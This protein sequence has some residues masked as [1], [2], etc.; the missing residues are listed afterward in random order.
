M[1]S[2]EQMRSS[3]TIVLGVLLLVVGLNALRIGDIFKSGEKESPVI[4]KPKI[5][6]REVVKGFSIQTGQYPGEDLIRIESCRIEKQRKGG[7]SFGAFNVLVID[8]LEICL[9]PDKPSAL[10]ILTPDLGQAKGRLDEKNPLTEEVYK[11]LAYYPK[12]S[13]IR[14]NH[15]SVGLM[16]PS[17]DT[18][19]DKALNILTAG[20]AESGCDQTLKLRDCEFLTLDGERMKSQNAILYVG[21]RICISSEGASYTIFGLSGGYIGK[22]L[23][24]TQNR[25]VV[26][27][28]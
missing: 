4:I 5:L 13:S 11:L 26:G 8:R 27:Q 22:H 16:G 12:F 17:G 3:V 20:R 28:R 10:T 24:L 18:K 21:D 6:T 15:L 2:S 14:I 25:K 1:R 7:F 19:D 23:K 9:P